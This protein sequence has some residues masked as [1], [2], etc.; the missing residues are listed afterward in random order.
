MHSWEPTDDVERRGARL[1]L[2]GHTH[3]G[4]VRPPFCGPL[5]HQTYRCPPRIGGCCWVGR[6]ALHIS[7][8]L[9]GTHKLRFLV[10]PRAVLF[11]LRSVS[12]RG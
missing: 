4:Q 10:R 1:V 9:G 6:A 7:H 12:S 11:T 2:A 3:G 8:G 5:V